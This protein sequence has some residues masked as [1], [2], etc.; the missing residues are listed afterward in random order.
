[1]W[2]F[3]ARGLLLFSQKFFSFLREVVITSNIGW[4]QQI[5]LSIDFFRTVLINACIKWWKITTSWALVLGYLWSLFRLLSDDT[6]TIMCSGFGF[7]NAIFCIPP[8]LIF[9]IVITFLR[10]S[11]QGGKVQWGYAY[12][13]H[14]PV[15]QGQ[16]T[17]LGTACKCRTLFD[18]CVVL[19]QEDSTSNHLQI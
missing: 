5:T 4:T 10:Q 1:M 11:V 2:P 16:T 17:I 13:K 14:Q 3:S 7:L 12:V 19:I 15:R 9:V 6:C 18:K 8:S